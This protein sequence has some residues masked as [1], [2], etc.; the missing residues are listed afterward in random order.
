MQHKNPKKN[1]NKRIGRPQLFPKIFKIEQ[2]EQSNTSRKYPYSNND[3]ILGD[4]TTIC[5]CRAFRYDGH[6][7]FTCDGGGEHRIKEVKK[8]DRIELFVIER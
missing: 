1:L 4:K 6:E 7:T 5:D 8:N 3:D 2:L